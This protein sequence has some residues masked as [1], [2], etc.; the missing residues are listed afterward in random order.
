MVL[1]AG[2]F[3]AAV[4]I[5]SAV[6]EGLTE[7]IRKLIPGREMPKGQVELMVF[8]IHF[9]VGALFAFMGGVYAEFIPDSDLFNQVISAF[10]FALG[11][12]FVHQL[13]K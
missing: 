6:M 13:K 8:V 1:E 7:K 4:T 11:P 10:V 5:L 9:I 2:V 12:D 3:V